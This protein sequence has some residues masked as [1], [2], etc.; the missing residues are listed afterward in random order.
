MRIDL[1]RALFR[2]YPSYRKTYYQKRQ[3]REMMSNASASFFPFWYST[4]ENSKQQGGKSKE[5]ATSRPG[6][7]L[8]Q[9]GCMVT[10]RES[11]VD[12]MV[13]PEGL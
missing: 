1:K 3:K 8:H 7:F 10:Q 11:P 4:Q 2:S 5:Q 9:K 12:L 13:V 6:T